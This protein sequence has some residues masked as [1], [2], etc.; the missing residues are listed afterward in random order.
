MV[1]D[2]L[3]PDEEARLVGQV[4]ERV[5]RKATSAEIDLAERAAELSVK[6]GLATPVTVE[7]SER[8]K[9]RWGSCTPQD[10]HIR[11]SSRLATLPEWVLDS[12]LVHEMAHL[13][14][15]DHSPEFQEIVNRYELTERA[16]GYLM[17][18]GEQPGTAR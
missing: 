13:E 17:A 14:V 18:V 15:A 11:I 8:Q 10:G 7:W 3:D 12:V 4:C 9:R 2:G 6:Y 5:M 1:P 16:T